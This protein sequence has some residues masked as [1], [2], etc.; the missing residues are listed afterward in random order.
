MKPFI[1]YSLLVIICHYTVG[2]QF[3]IDSNTLKLKYITSGLVQRTFELEYYYSYEFSGY[4]YKKF[5]GL[6]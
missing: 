2:K 4:T 3:R 1:I 6:L 5:E